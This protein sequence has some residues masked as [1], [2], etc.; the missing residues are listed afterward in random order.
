M[1]LTSNRMIIRALA[2]A[3]FFMLIPITN[4]LASPQYIQCGSNQT[5][6]SGTVDDQ[7]SNGI[8][9]VV[10]VIQTL[11]GYQPSGGGITQTAS[12]GTWSITIDTQCP[13]EAN[14]YWTGPGGTTTTSERPLLLSVSDYSNGATETVN[15][16]EQQIDY[17]LFYEYSNS[18]CGASPCT[19]TDATISFSTTGSYTIGV[20]ADASITG[21]IADGFLSTT[22][23]GSLGTTETIS[24][25]LGY[26]TTNDAPEIVVYP[27]GYAVKVEDTSGNYLTY[28]LPYSLSS[29]TAQSTSDWLSSSTARTDDD[30]K[31]VPPFAGVPPCSGSGC[32][33]SSTYSVSLSSTLTVSSSV[34]VDFSVAWGAFSLKTTI[35]FSGS[36]G[37]TLQESM[38][39]TNTSTTEY[40][41]YIMYFEGNSQTAG[42]DIHAWFYGYASS[43]PTS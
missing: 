26:S 17:N 33:S 6:W 41:C 21:S 25:S 3:A 42:V 8:A 13:I 36:S 31:N 19:G 43:C 34:G 4:A 5:T 29:Y 7:E 18:G 38:T 20:S 28:V 15:V 11:S 24:D 35:S 12:N 23:D 22:P 9:G 14:F 30:N 32:Q 40:A 39:L 16:W 1:K 37:T 2:L 27:T 10:V